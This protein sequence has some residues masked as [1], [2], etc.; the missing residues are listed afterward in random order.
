VIARLLVPAQGGFAGMTLCFR[1][2]R[3]ANSHDL[4]MWLDLVMNCAFHLDIHS[5]LI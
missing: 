1:G 2:L 4:Y 3:L 5:F